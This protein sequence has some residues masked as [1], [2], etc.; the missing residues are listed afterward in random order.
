MW[1]ASTRWM[2]ISAG[3]LDICW[4]TKTNYSESFEEKIE[5]VLK[6]IDKLYI[7]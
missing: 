5:E 3:G 7:F 2:Q 6:V 4:K 1:N